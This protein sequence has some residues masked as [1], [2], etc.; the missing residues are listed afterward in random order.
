MGPAVVV[1]RDSEVGNVSF[2]ITE[3]E[4]DSILGKFPQSNLSSE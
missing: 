1:L 3:N 4:P 2:E